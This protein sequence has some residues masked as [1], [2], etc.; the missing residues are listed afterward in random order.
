MNRY[1]I[2]YELYELNINGQISDAQMFICGALLDE[3]TDNQVESLAPTY[4]DGLL[5]LIDLD[6]KDIGNYL[7]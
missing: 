6:P 1:E 3:L 4:A 5:G 7:D 2:K